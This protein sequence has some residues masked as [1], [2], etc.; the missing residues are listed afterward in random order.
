MVQVQSG[1]GPVFYWA[2]KLAEDVKGHQAWGVARC[3]SATR[4]MHRQRDALLACNTDDAAA[5]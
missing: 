1:G 3:G 4:H 2:R 5:T